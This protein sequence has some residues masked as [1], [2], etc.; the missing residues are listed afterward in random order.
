MKLPLPANAL[1]F[2]RTY[3][4]GAACRRALFHARWPDGFQC[5]ACGHGR[6]YELRCRK[7]SVECARCGK[8]LSLTAETMFHGSKLP[9]TTLFRIVYMIVAE[10]SGTN[11]MAISRQT[12]VSHPTALL[13]MRK[14][15]SIMARRPREKLSGTVEVDESI[16]GSSGKQR[17]RKL[18]ANQAWI[19]VLVEDR[20]EEGM[21]RVRLQ[22]VENTGEEV[23]GAVIEENVVAGAKIRSDAWMGYVP[24]RHKGYEHD[25]RNVSKSGREAHE[26]LPLVH[27]VASLLKR[28][29]LGIVH[30]SWTHRWLPW[31]LADFEFRLNRR[32]SKRRPLL[33]NRVLEVGLGMRPPTRLAYANFAKMDTCT[34]L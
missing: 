20:G 16:L 13:W 31:L 14:V 28:H 22:A 23:L 24:L 25:Q 19:L 21:G 27:M 4:T 1:E 29:V 26:S 18:A 34:L 30:G 32:R 33:F 7:A 9:L 11:G 15:R 5:P 10:K 3:A 6:A 8:H 12:G 2:D 17:G